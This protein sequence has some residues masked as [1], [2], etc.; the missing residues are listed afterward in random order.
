MKQTG[1]GPFDSVLLHSWF[2][3]STGWPGFGGDADNKYDGDAYGMSLRL[4]RTGIKKVLADNSMAK[5]DLLTFDAC[6]M[7]SYMLVTE[8]KNL[9][10]YY[11]ASEHLE[12]GH[13]YEYSGIKPLTGG[14]PSTPTDYARSIADAFMAIEPQQSVKTQ[15][16]T[17]MSKVEAF[18]DAFSKLLEYVRQGALQQFAEVVRPW[19][20]G[21]LNVQR[22]EDVFGTEQYAD[23]GDLLA[24]VKY[25]AG[26]DCPQLTAL[27]TTC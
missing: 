20:V 8:L 7:S 9:T 3:G 15:A 12:P 18:S 6:L 1:N 21:Q 14:K 27:S 24:R 19:M 4:I 5:L 13:G 23:L 11:L 10:H 25:S 22:I 2:D 26:A 17:D 16:I